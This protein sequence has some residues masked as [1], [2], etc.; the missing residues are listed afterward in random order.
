TSI[1][2]LDLNHAN[3]FSHRRHANQTP[4]REASSRD[5][6]TIYSDNDPMIMASRPGVNGKG[7]ACQLATVG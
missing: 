3:S 2:K 4:L 7:T 5:V 6:S 1:G